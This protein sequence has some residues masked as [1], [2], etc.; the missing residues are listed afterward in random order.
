MI[1]KLR[2]TQSA[3]FY[4]RKA[5][6]TDQAIRTLFNKI[7]DDASSPSSPIVRVV[8]QPLSAEV[9]VSALAL[10]YKRPVPFLVVGTGK[11]EIVYGFVL[12]VEH[13]EMVAVFKSGLDLSADFRKDHLEPIGRTRVEHAIARHDVVFEKLNLR[14]MSTSRLALRTKTLESHDLKNAVT[15][16]SASRFIPQGYRVRHAG[17]SMSATPS[18]G[19]IAAR[20]DK[21]GYQAAADWAVQVMELLADDKNLVSPFIRQFARALDLSQRGAG[22]PTWF[23]VDTMGLADALFESDEKIRLV[24]QVKGVWKALSRAQT[25]AILA[26]LDIPFD[27]F[28]DGPDH[29]LQMTGAGVGHI[30]FNRSRIAFRTLERP[31][32]AGVFVEEDSVPLGSKPKELIRYL[33]GEDMFTVLFDDLALA[34][35]DGSLYRDEGLT[36]GGSTFLQHLQGQAV[37]IDADDEKG[38]FAIGQ[39]EFGPKSVFR[40]VV[41]TIATEDVLVCDD[42]G[43]E[44]ADFIG[45]ATVG[46]G[47]ITFYHAKHGKRSLSASAF[48]EAVGQRIKNL[49]RMTLT[50]D[51]MSSKYRGWEKVYRGKKVTSDIARIAKGGTR[52]DIEEKISKVAARLDVARRAVIV[53]SSLSVEEVEGVFKAA[54]EGT[55]PKPHFV[56]LYWLLMGF[57]AACA[58]VGV[59]G[60]VYCQP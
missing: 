51:T 7:R 37:L 25:E 3:Y 43:D 54:K 14:N 60:Y 48:H 4:G 30:R 52:A 10:A 39:T 33:D 38:K 34:Y 8:Q 44:W 32:L 1:D 5:P 22:R 18:T 24:R 50:A 23:L 19:R 16:A 55:P 31:L 46:P 40:L 17:R 2:I 58:E 36:G 20:A 12:L 15:A 11:V 9:N 27:I 41:D 45:V 29:E 49:G 13:D 28:G 21:T 42:L 6:I 57:F 47:A 53:T 59:V 56:Q 35:I 26:D